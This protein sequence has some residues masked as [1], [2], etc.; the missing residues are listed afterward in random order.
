MTLSKKFLSLFLVFTMTQSTF[1]FG[2]NGY[3]SDEE[4]FQECLYKDCSKK[5]QEFDINEVL[6]SNPYSYTAYEKSLYT[7]V[8]E[9]RVCTQKELQ[10]MREHE[11][12]LSGLSAKEFSKLLKSSPDSRQPGYFIPLSL[13]KEEL[14]LLAAGTSLGLVVFS[15]DE[16]IMDFIQEHKTVQTEMV[17]TVGNLLGREAI[18]PIAAGSYFLGVVFKDGKLKQV[19]LLTVGA[20]LA[21]QIVTEAFKVGFSRK[22][23]NENVGPY[24]FFEKGNKS[25]FS[26]H[27]VGAFSLATVIAETYKEKNW[28][29]YVAYGLATLTAYA[30]MHDHKHWASDVLA[31]AIMGHLITKATIRLLKNDSSAGGFSVYPTI[32]PITGDF[33]INLEYS[34]KQ[35][36]APFKCAKLPEGEDKIRACIEEAIARSEA[37]KP[38]F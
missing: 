34:E 2:L 19:G 21:A 29:P 20:G 13:T 1:A 33:M 14:I 15:Q 18:I 31:G 4:F 10:A 11:A 12:E 7:C 25:F 38:I 32:N 24:E 23:P 22:R 16:E 17:E 26:G 27:A 8:R 3:M 5:N 30:R 35:K 36:E 6:D 9:K 37:K 28:V